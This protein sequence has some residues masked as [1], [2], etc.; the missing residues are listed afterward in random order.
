MRACNGSERPRQP[1]DS[2]KGRRHS[3][4]RTLFL[5]PILSLV[6]STMS[7]LPTLSA[8]L[9]VIWF[10][11]VILVPSMRPHSNLSLCINTLSLLLYSK[12]LRSLSLWLLHHRPR[13]L[14]E[15]RLLIELW[16]MPALSNRWSNPVSTV[17]L[18]VLTYTILVLG[19][20]GP[21]ILLQNV[22]HLLLSPLKL[23]SALIGTM[24]AS[25]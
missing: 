5:F 21:L 17:K 11:L 4:S 10:F 1:S 16:Q 18:I 22:L 8:S 24:L 25:S 7:L 13:V 23:L 12:W 14:R 3:R 6:S 19:L 20:A 2:P 9:P 15:C